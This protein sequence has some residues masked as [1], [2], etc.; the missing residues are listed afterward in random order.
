MVSGH[1][2]QNICDAWQQ[3]NRHIRARLCCC[4]WI[5]IQSITLLFHWVF[6]EGKYTMMHS[7]SGPTSSHHLSH[8]GGAWQH[9]V[10]A[11]PTSPS[12]LLLL[13]FLP[14]P[15]IDGAIFFS[16]TH[17]ALHFTGQKTMLALVL[18]LFYSAMF[19][20]H[21]YKSCFY[22]TPLIL[23]F[24]HA[25]AFLSR[26]C[27]MTCCSVGKLAGVCCICVRNIS[28]IFCKNTLE[29]FL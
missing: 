12:F 29:I 13:S 24:I 16:S 8:M 5:S 18:S 11:A 27:F 17:M 14:A 28:L 1:F 2:G 9:P 10:G 7:Y 25:S 3:R 19:Q 6:T 21:M 4:G 15:E 20:P 26:A 22:L 23:M